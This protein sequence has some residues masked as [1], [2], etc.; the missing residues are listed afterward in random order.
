MKKKW[1]LLGSALLVLFAVGAFMIPR[2]G[3]AQYCRLF[4]GPEACTQV[5]LCFKGEGLSIDRGADK[6]LMGPHKRFS[7][8]LDCKEVA[9][10][11]PDG[12]TTYIISRIGGGPERQL[13]CVDIE[14]PV[15]YQQYCDVELGADPKN[16]PF[17]HFHGPLTV[18][19]VNVNGKLP[20]GL[21]LRRGDKPTDLQAFV[22]TFDPANGC[23][24]VVQSDQR[25]QPGTPYFPKGVYPV[26]EVEFPS[27]NP[28]LPA[29]KRTYALDKTC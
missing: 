26:A 9:I 18:K 10:S 2:C 15:Q 1:L 28:G 14:G 4:F 19:V 16:A 22:G 8:R 7:S 21:A 17:A 6:S 3:K 11:G 20:P 24:V 25:Y 13:I 5:L 12:K 29:I 27:Q 23:W